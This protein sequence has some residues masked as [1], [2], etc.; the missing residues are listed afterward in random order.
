[1]SDITIGLNEQPVDWIDRD[2][3]DGGEGAALSGHRCL[4]EL[5]D[6]ELANAPEWDKPLLEM[7]QQVWEDSDTRILNFSDSATPEFVKERIRESIM[8]GAVFSDF[9]GVPSSELM[10]IREHMTETLAESDGWT[11]DGLADQLE[12]IDGIDSSN[13]RTIARTESASV[14]NSAREEGYKDK[15]QADD[16]FYWSGNLDGRHTEACEWLVKKTNPF[17]GGNP[18]GLSELKELIEEAPEHDSDMQDNL[19]R[20]DDFVVHPN[21]RK[22]WVRAP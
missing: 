9:E 4:A 1:M 7:H 18:V 21:E 16:T 3:E 11:V 19:A 8:G 2:G 22:T 12:Q 6:D 14:L 15:G 13:A 17:H 5:S 10:Q 20:P